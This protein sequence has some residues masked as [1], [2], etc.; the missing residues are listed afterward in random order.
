MSKNRL[1]SYAILTTLPT[2]ANADWTMPNQQPGGVI[3]DFDKAVMNMTNWLLGII[4]LIAVLAII[5]GGVQYLTAA[6]NQDQVRDAKKTIQNA[7]MG[8][9]IAGIAY[10]VVKVI[11]TVILR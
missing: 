2:A 6:G 8:L 5:W 4:S 9:V 7:F 1:L 3:T 11:V 10:A